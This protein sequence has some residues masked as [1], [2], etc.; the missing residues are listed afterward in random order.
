MVA[1]AINPT[2]QGYPLPFII[3]IQ[4]ITAM[5]SEQNIYLPRDI[6]QS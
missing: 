3:F 1:P 6:I 2:G 5:T 4:L